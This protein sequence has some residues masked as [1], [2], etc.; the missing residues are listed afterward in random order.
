VQERVTHLVHQPL[1]QTQE[2]LPHVSFSAGA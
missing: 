2:E 1:N